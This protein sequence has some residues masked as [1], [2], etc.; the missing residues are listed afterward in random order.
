MLQFGTVRQ[1]SKAEHVKL[2][3]FKQVMKLPKCLKRELKEWPTTK[4]SSFT[5]QCMNLNRLHTSKKTFMTEQEWARIEVIAKGPKDEQQTL[6][7]QWALKWREYSLTDARYVLAVD[8]L[9]NDRQLELK[10]L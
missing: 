10:G 4:R 5:N 7:A 2:W 9:R 1:L 6:R 8:K 3:N